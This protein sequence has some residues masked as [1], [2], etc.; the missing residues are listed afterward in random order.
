MLLSEYLERYHETQSAFARRSGVPQT[1]I[2]DIILRNNG[3]H[4]AT[5]AKIIEATGGLVSL[6]DLAGKDEASGDPA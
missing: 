1:T 2:S 5:A 4:A 6:T 3:T